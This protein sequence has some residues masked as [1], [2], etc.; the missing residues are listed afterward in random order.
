MAEI[1]LIMNF[2]HA[3]GAVAH[4]SLLAFQ[5]MRSAARYHG[6]AVQLVRG[7]GDSK[8]CYRASCAGELG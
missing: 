6:V 4:W 3:E 7:F 8:D 1:S 5:Q 2:F